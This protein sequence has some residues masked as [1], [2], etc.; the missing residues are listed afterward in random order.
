M[1][2]FHIVKEEAGMAID[3]QLLEILAC[4]DDKGP[5]YYFEEEQFLLCPTCRRR[6]SV[7]DDIPVM[8]MD[9]AEQFDET[10]A[11]KL[12]ELANSKGIRLTFEEGGV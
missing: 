5:L 11:A 7:T 9:E 10:T 6:Y 1:H 3:S 2:R 12:V 8:L 4:P